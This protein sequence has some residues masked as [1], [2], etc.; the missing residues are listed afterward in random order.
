ML[1][2]DISE[3]SYAIYGDDSSGDTSW[4]T[5]VSIHDDQT[6]E[7][8]DETYLDPAVFSVRRKK[9]KR[10][11]ESVRL[12]TDLYEPSSPVESNTRKILS[13][14][15]Q[16]KNDEERF[17]NNFETKTTKLIPC[18]KKGGKGWYYLV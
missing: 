7:A 18:G 1:S 5:D 8:P 15:L 4:Y 3:N 10:K 12:S 2:D 14:N 11:R 13:R 9:S 6:G 17:F 16:K